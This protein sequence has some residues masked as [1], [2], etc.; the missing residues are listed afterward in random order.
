M[1]KIKILAMAAL[2][3]LGLTACSN[4]DNSYRERYFTFEQTQYLPSAAGTYTVTLDNIKN[5]VEIGAVKADWMTI[6]TMETKESGKSQIAVTVTE[7]ATGENR[8]APA[9]VLTSKPNTVYLTIIQGVTNMDNPN[10]QET[11]QPAYTPGL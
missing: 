1:K 6:A 9:V 7:N 11:D 8:T 10:E 5:T 3:A 4:A 2:V